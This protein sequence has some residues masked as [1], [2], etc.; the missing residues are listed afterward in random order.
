MGQVFCGNVDRGEV[1]GAA[2][3]VQR[4]CV[5]FLP[6]SCSSGPLCSLKGWGGQFCS[7]TICVV[8]HEDYLY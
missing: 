2:L 6:P 5:E 7:C 1:R 8:Q 4:K 3:L